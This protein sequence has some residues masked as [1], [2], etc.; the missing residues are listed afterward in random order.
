MV[1]PMIRVGLLDL[2]ADD[3]ADKYEVTLSYLGE[4][5]ETCPLR[6]GRGTLE[7]TAPDLRKKSEECVRE[8][9]GA[10]GGFEESKAGPTVEKQPEIPIVRHPIDFSKGKQ[11]R[12]ERKN[13]KGPSMAKRLVDMAMQGGSVTLFRTPLGEPYIQVWREGHFEVRPLDESF[14]DFLANEFWKAERDVPTSSAK[15][16]ALETLSAMAREDGE[17]HD[18]RIRVTHVDDSQEVWYDLGD[19]QW[20]AVRIT[21]GGW[22]VVNNREILFKRTSYTYEQPEPVRGRS[23]SLDELLELINIRDW[24][25]PML[26]IL[27]VTDLLAIREQIGVFAM[28]GEGSGKSSLTR[29]EKALIDPQGID[30]ANVSQDPVRDEDFELLLT[31]MYIAPIDNI[32]RLSGQRSDICCVA[33]TGGL[34]C[35]RA[36]YRNREMVRDSYRCALRLNGI[37]NPISRPDALERML[38]FNFTEKPPKL[39]STSTWWTAFN[40][41]K[42]YALADLFD[43]ASEALKI[44]HELPE[45][46]HSPRMGEWFRWAQAAAMAIGLTM[47]EFNTLFNRFVERENFEALE[48]DQLTKVLIN[49]AE[50][51]MFLGTASELLDALNAKA[52]SMTVDM[53]DRSWPKKEF[54]LGK[55]LDRL[56]VTMGKFGYELIHGLAARE[57]GER[58]PELAVMA[59]H[60]G[61]TDRMIVLRKKREN[62]TQASNKMQAIPLL[63]EV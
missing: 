5:A 9:D 62:S 43:L 55:R 17:L 12:E 39:V 34:R 42:P 29:A 36:H 54:V 37:S 13:G 33:V 3:V 20:R 2:K 46:E 38:I 1:D 48:Q 14:M 59:S 56:Q 23:G 18:L 41:L 40:N 25:T 44:Y 10:R 31:Q 51:G 11:G 58:L 57:L 49:V 21:T 22:S 53:R 15:R 16:A 6:E 7:S 45:P 27:F 8:R 30:E 26:K 60:Y 24:Q 47:Q 35:R 52:L 50:D 28:G 63:P 32:S 19:P 4:E 61:R